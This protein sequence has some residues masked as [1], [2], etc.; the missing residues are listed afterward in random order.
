MLEGWKHLGWREV[1]IT[2]IAILEV[3]CVALYLMPRFS[4]LGAIFLTGYLGGAIS[5]HYR[6][7]E[8]VVIQ[9]VMGVLVWGGVYLREPRLRAILPVRK[10]PG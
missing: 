7:G 9:A 2:E 5:T 8:S 10:P 4:V 1:M 3:A 6:L